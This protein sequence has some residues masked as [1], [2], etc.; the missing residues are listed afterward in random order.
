VQAE[1]PGVL[2]GV[3]PEVQWIL[4]TTSP[5]IAAA[6]DPS[7]VLAL[8]RLPEQREIVLFAGEHALTH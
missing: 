3:L 7:E 2:R 8:R 1:L 6:C 5:L 4:T